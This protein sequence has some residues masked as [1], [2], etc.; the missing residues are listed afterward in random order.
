[1]TFLALKKNLLLATV[2]TGICS[3]AFASAAYDITNIGGSSSRDIENGQIVRA[4]SNSDFSSNIILGSGNSETVIAENVSGAGSLNL[5]GGAVYWTT[6]AFI[7]GNLERTLHVY[8]SG[9]TSVVVTS[10]NEMRGFSYDDE[11]NVAWVEMVNGGN[12]VFYYNGLS[13]TQITSG[14][15]GFTISDDDRNIHTDNGN[16]VW[17]EGFTLFMWN[18]ISTQQA[19]LEDQRIS[20]FASLD[21][22]KLVYISQDASTNLSEVF[23]YQS[24]S[25]TQLTYNG[26]SKTKVLAEDG[27]IAYQVSNITC[28]SCIQSSDLYKL[29]NGS[30]TLLSER[31]VTVDIDG[32]KVVWTEGL[33]LDINDA[34][35]VNENGATTQIESTGPRFNSMM[36]EGNQIVWTT[37]NSAQ[38]GSE[39]MLAGPAAE[40]VVV[41]NLGAEHSVTQIDL[42]ETVVVEV[43]QWVGWTWSPNVIGFGFSSGDGAPINGFSVVDSEGNSH[44][45]YGYWTSINQ[46]FFWETVTLT[47]PAQPGRVISVQWW[48]TAE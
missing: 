2:I 41:V 27:M 11:G 40:Q 38:G 42:S 18:G 28:S 23:A 17:R 32:D 15:T 34:L 44:E 24:G 43:S 25:L 36:A 16:V 22:D 1:M 26:V 30:S 21:G 33:S 47:I 29:E 8:E 31:S 45:L 5:S 10:A 13:I 6:A 3:S 48:A 12:E 14:H 46:P 9:E 19:S 20:R 7:D 4:T 37:G 39:T 35:Y